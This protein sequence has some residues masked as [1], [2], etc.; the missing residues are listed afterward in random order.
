LLLNQSEK[1]DSRHY[2][3][4]GMAWAGW[5][6]D[7]YDLMLL[8]FLVVP[9]QRELGLSQSQISL[10]MGVSLAATAVG[11]LLFGWL[12]DRYGRKPVL[13]ATILTYSIGAFCCGLS[14]NLWMLLAFRVVTGLGVGGEWATGQTLIG[15]TFPAKTRARY[16]ALMQTGAPAG[17]ALATLV[18]TFAEPLF[19]QAWGGAWGWRACFLISVLP[20]LLVILIR[21]SMPESDIWEEWQHHPD[22]RG[23]TRGEFLT[24][25][26]AD[27]AVRRLFLLCLVLALTDMSA[28]WFTYIWMPSY[29]YKQLDFSMATSGVWMLVTQ[30]GGV[31]GYASFG[32]VADWKGRRIA[33]ALYSILWAAGLFSVTLCW[34]QIAAF[35]QFALFC[36]FVIGLGTGNFSGYGPIFSELFTTRVRNTAMG[37]A[38]NL[39]R[40]VQFFTPLVITWMAARATNGTEHDLGLGISIGAFFA[41]FTGLW[42]WTLPE[43]RGTQILASEVVRPQ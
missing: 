8:S 39:A 21:R 31:I 2:V 32:V 13:S 10:L 30:A 22:H 35:P 9:I 28:Y 38:F 29:L 20:A 5:L 18:G 6:F 19:E 17:I 16:A 36:M 42:I 41:L 37:T 33:Y 26:K 27:V 25:L 12:A 7:F 43:T 11:G 4:L 1:P 24:L 23:S 40:G 34:A 15:E 3:I 14:P